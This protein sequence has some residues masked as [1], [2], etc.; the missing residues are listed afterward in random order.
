MKKRRIF[1][2]FIMLTTLISLLPDNPANALI[3][4]PGSVVLH[5]E[6]PV[7][8]SPCECGK[9]V[10]KLSPQEVYILESHIP[11][12][13]IQTNWYRIATWRGEKWIKLKES[14]W[15][16]QEQL[17][18]AYV[19]IL[20][21]TNLYNNPELEG[22]TS[23]VISP[24]TLH[25]NAR[26]GDYFRIDT[27]LGQQWIRRNAEMLLE[28]E[29]KEEM[30]EL[31]SITA[32]F[33]QPDA[34]SPQVTELS[35]QIV[36]SFE[37]AGNWYHIDTWLGPKWVNPKIAQPEKP[38]ASV[39]T[40]K[41]S[42][43]AQLYRYPSFEAKSL[44]TLAPQ[45]VKIYERSG[46]WVHIHSDWV[47]DAWLYPMPLA[48]DY[49]PPKNTAP[50]DFNGAWNFRQTEIGGLGSREY[51]FSVELRETGFT[52]N[53]SIERM[54][55]NAGSDLQFGAN[56]FNVSS[57]SLAISNPIRLQ[58]V[59]YREQGDE[60][61]LVWK[62]Q[63]PAF[64]EPSIPSKGMYEWN[65]PLWELTDLDGKLVPAGDYTVQLTSLQPVT[66]VS[67]ETTEETAANFK[68][69]YTQFRFRILSQ[70]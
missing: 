3:A 43:S 38:V 64:T 66:Y 13:G 50:I 34:S 11:E 63:L 2:S 17:E 8:D 15:K 67:S 56:L 41:I 65:G 26:S 37:R 49:L 29:K 68:G 16:G 47:G 52:W 30:L 42:K 69:L 62:S 36:H 22:R 53:N 33:E 57:E 19:V 31:P 21:P 60:K 39:E 32:V 9:P 61:Q 59:I 23:V 18:N 4:Y 28:V 5:Q 54:Q 12:D 10:L 55:L 48:K 27:W 35:S 25:V 45:N 58:I 1:S 7:Y 20:K 14:D 44:G 24:Q 51:P 46:G 70:P 6:T 40:V